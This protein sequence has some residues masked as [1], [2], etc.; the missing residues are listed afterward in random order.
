M[1]L[2]PNE[3]TAIPRASDMLIQRVLRLPGD[4]ELHG[5]GSLL[6]RLYRAE[7]RGLVA[8]AQSLVRIRELRNLI[9]HKYANEKL[10]ELYLTISQLA[11]E[12]GQIARRTN[13]YARAPA[14]RLQEA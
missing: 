3:R 9:A 13:D 4:L 5:A 7:K 12:L 2:N 11:P 10:T 8:H 1:S 6:D 14:Q